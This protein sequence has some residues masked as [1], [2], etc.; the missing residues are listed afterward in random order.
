MP[1]LSF[2][3]DFESAGSTR[4]PSITKP[5]PTTTTTTA[6][7]VNP[8]IP[9]PTVCSACTNNFA[10]KLVRATGDWSI[11]A[12]SATIWNGAEPRGLL[13]FEE[14]ICSYTLILLNL[15]PNKDYKWKITI[16]DSFKENY[17]CSGSNGPDCGFKTNQ[18]G[19]VRLI[20]KPNTNPPQLLAD[21]NVAECGDNICE[22]GETCSYCPED[23]G[24]C[25]PPV[26]GDG[27][28]EEPETFMTCP[29]DCPNEL[30]GCQRFND[31]GCRS[32]SQIDANPG[33]EKRRWQTPKPGTKGYQP[34]FQ[35]Y[36]ALTGYAD[37]RYTS[38]ARTEA[39]LCIIAIHK[40]QGKVTFKY[41]F[42]GQE[43]S[44]NCKR[45]STAHKDEVQLRVEASDGTTLDVQPFQLIWNV[46]SLAP[47]AGD[48]RNGQK[49]G[50]AEFFG[51][52]H[53]DVE[54]ECE[55]LSKAGY[56]GAKLFP[57]HEQVISWQPFDDAMNPWYI[58]L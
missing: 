30:P 9:C 28:C 22:E 46:Q 6:K 32:G 36:Y 24:E 25:P 44:T 20:V 33:V 2:D 18:V 26:C 15:K 47:R 49:G 42:D 55:L 1:N 52:P 45:Y 14:K 21:Y 7:P 43:Q 37:V 38:A 48:Y 39:D 17:G 10:S 29:E 13:N 50:I 54:K 27:V 41:L 40:D 11:D 56:L 12:G 5:P 19:A 8:I 4:D 57:I 34:S 58:Y 51:W 35:H 53:K 3:Y 31:E 23:C 16:D